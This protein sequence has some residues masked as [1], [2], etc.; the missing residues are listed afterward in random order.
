MICHETQPTQPNWFSGLEVQAMWKLLTND[1]HSGICLDS[2][3]A[4]FLHTQ[5]F[6][7]NLPNTVFFH[8]QLTC[9]HSNNQ[10]TFAIH[11]W[12]YSLD[13]DFSLISDFP[14]MKSFI[15]SLWSF[16][17]LLCLSKARMS[18]LA[19]SSYTY[20]SIWSVCDG[21]LPDQNRQVYLFARYSSFVP[22]CL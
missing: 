4:N 18:D 22:R 12:P 19:L 13:D 3:F 8:V 16:L 15:T 20:W 21:V 2:I 7:Y 9:N 5:I 11:H 14:L 10:Q 6:S 1:Y 17:N